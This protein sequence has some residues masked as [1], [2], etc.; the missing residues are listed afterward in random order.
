MT[1]RVAAG[2]LV[3]LP[4]LEALGEHHEVSV[5]TQPDRAQGARPPPR[6]R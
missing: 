4:A 2:T 5:L 1:L 3:A 6:A